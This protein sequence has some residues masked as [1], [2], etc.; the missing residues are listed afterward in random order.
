MKHTHSPRR[1]QTIS[2]CNASFE[3]SI[4]RGGILLGSTST[5]GF[6]EL[7]DVKRN[8]RLWM[9]GTPQG[10]GSKQFIS[11]TATAAGVEWVMG[12]GPITGS[13]P[14]SSAEYA[15]VVRDVLHE[16]FDT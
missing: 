3:G 11:V 1:T 2:A 13:G 9:H 8:P 7:G 10:G 15:T 5:L 6:V 12:N 4:S 16:A 14:L